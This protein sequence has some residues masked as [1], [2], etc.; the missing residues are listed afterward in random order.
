MEDL[1]EKRAFVR[2]KVAHNIKAMAWANSQHIV[3]QVDDVSLG[4]IALSYDNDKN[5]S[6]QPEEIS[7]LCQEDFWGVSDLPVKLIWQR[8]DQGSESAQRIKI[9]LCFQ[10]INHQKKSQLKYFIRNFSRQNN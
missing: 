7:I 10:K 6:L 3:C 9:G 5:R 4:G 1:I 8:N 2:F